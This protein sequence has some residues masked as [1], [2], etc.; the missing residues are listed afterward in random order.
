MMKISEMIAMLAEVMA[1]HGDKE[2]VIVNDY[3]G[4]VRYAMGMTVNGD[5]VIIDH[6][7]YGE[8]VEIEMGCA[9]IEAFAEMMAMIGGEQ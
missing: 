6:I 8:K 2:V 1:D 3:T 5:D 7:S 9:M 4:E